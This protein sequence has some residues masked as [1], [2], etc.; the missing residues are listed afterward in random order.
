MAYSILLILPG[1]L[2]GVFVCIERLVQIIV[3]APEKNL[4]VPMVCENQPG[5][6][7]LYI[8]LKTNSDGVR[9]RR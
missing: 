9:Q 1:T 4:F 5:A 8:I 3:A 7:L 6:V 2:K